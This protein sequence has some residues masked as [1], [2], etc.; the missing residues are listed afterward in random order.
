MWKV[1]IKGYPHSATKYA[2]KT[3]YVWTK[4]NGNA[5]TIN[6]YAIKYVSA[7]SD[8]ISNASDAISDA[9]STNA[10]ATTTKQ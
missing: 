3:S 4:P 6:A 10:N 7:T 1:E 2:T 5:R 8:A 9:A